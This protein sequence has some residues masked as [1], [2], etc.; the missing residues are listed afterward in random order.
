MLKIPRDNNNDCSLSESA[1]EKLEIEK[2][3][4]EMSLSTITEMSRTKSVASARSIDYVGFANFPNQV[5]RR[6]VKNGFE[7]TLMVVGEF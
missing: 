7:F 3:S 4:A 2:K 6:C 1:T 5:F